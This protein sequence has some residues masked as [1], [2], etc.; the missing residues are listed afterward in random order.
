MAQARANPI[1][2]CCNYFLAPVCD[3]SKQAN[4][5]FDSLT[6]D[7]DL[8]K[9]LVWENITRPA[10]IYFQMF[11]LSFSITF[12]S[13]TCYVYYPSTKYKFMLIWSIQAYRFIYVWPA[14]CCH[15]VLHI[16]RYYNCIPMSMHEYKTIHQFSF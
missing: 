6:K 16:N 7:N 3:I 5:W 4:F 10:Y 1:K 11:V 15:L 13:S 9:K 2:H 8:I 14:F 12:S